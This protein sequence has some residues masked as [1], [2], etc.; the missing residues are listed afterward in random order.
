MY[1]NSTDNELLQLI[2]TGDERAFRV[3][4]DRYYTPLSI[5]A[6][7]ML[8][9]EEMAIDVVQSFFVALY[10]QSKTLSVSNARSFCYQ[11]VHNRCLNELKHQKV[12]SA[13]A[14]RTQ[15]TAEHPTSNIEDNIYA[16]EL[17]ARLTAAINQLP[18]QCQNI[19]KMSRF[20]GLTN[21]EIAIRLDI[22]KRTVET[23]ISKA[24]QELRK[25]A[26]LAKAILLLLLLR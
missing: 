22:S 9:D 16:A 21:D 7:R 3:L 23:Q 4:F 15:A 6:L 20:E 8:N 18:S 24:L 26:G 13:F 1:Q 14:E 25:W 11:S 5:Y 19:F 2:A 12:R 10:E 17:E